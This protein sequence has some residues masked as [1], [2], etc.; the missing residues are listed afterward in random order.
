[1]PATA[2]VAVTSVGLTTR[3]VNVTPA[4]PVSVSPATKPVPVR[5]TVWDLVRVPA[6]VVAGSSFGPATNE[7]H[8]LQV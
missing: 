6:I 5:C 7:A 2:I 1:M 3:S 4:G 8:V